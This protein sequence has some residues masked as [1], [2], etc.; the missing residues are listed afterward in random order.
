MSKT[1]HNREREKEAND[2]RKRQTRQ[3]KRKIGKLWIDKLSYNEW[4]FNQEINQ[5][6][7][8][9]EHVIALVLHFLALFP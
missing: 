9:I 3:G 2:D 4:N 6:Y 8:T 5:K 7:N 1:I